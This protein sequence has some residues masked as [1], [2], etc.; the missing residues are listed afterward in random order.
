MY[1]CMYIYIYIYIYMYILY[2]TLNLKPENTEMYM[3]KGNLKHIFHLQILC[4]LY[5]I[6]YSVYI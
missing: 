4:C 6:V 3:F 5:E 1:E 2:I